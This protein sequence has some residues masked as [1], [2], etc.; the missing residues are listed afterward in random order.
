MAREALRAESVTPKST[1]I[2][3]VYLM[4]DPTHLLTR[5]NL[6]KWELPCC[7]TGTKQNEVAGDAAFR[8]RYVT[9]RWKHGNRLP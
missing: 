1:A 6:M 7:E 9:R 3:L 5:T 8:T 2:D 4:G